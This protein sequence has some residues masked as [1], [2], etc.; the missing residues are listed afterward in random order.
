MGKNIHLPDTIYIGV[1]GIKIFQRFFVVVLMFGLIVT[2]C[3]TK[4]QTTSSNQTDASKQTEQ[5][6]SK[7]KDNSMTEGV[8]VGNLAPKF[9]LK[10]LD[11]KNISFPSKSG[12]PAMIFF[13]AS[14]CG[15]CKKE[16]PAIVELAKKYEGKVEFF[17]INTTNRD[18]VEAANDY[19]QQYGIPFP[20]LLDMKGEVGK[21]YQL[22]GTPTYYFVDANG[23]M[24]DAH[25]GAVGKEMIEQSLQKLNK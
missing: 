9:E 22:Q 14:W 18:D 2:G 5:V 19:V 24:V 13:W 21:K 16:T 4:D 23:V 8:A 11:G 12:K 25:I 15:Y 7:E 3:S 1:S 20:T 10:S 6:D 17:G